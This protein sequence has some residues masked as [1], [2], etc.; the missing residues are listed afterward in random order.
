MWDTAGLERFSTLSISYFQSA[1]AAILCY[2]LNNRESFGLLSQHILDTVDRSKT[3]KIF[4]C[5]NKLD[6]VSQSKQCD[7]VT[8]EDI[9]KFRDECDRVITGSYKVSCKSGYMVR[10]MFEDMAQAIMRNVYQ[11]FDPSTITL[12]HLPST[13]ED[14]EKKKCCT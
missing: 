6:L 14:G 8:D 13:S 11:K 7:I 4:L 2:S 5:G 3:A 1:T 9:V 10:D 12:S